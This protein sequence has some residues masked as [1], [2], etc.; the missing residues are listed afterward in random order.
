MSPPTCSADKCA[1]RVRINA[2]K[3][4]Y[5]LRLS[6]FFRSGYRVTNTAAT[7]PTTI[8]TIATTSMASRRHVPY[9]LETSVDRANPRLNAMYGF[10]V[11]RKWQIKGY[12]ERSRAFSG[13]NSRDSRQSGGKSEFER[14]DN[15]R[16]VGY[17]MVVS[18]ISSFAQVHAGN[19]TVVKQQQGH[20]NAC[21]AGEVCGVE[22]IGKR[23]A[24]V[25]VS[26]HRDHLPGASSSSYRVVR[27]KAR[28]QVAQVA[29]SETPV[30]G[31]CYREAAR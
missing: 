18:V 22:C 11:Q 10:R 12:G 13:E 20:C 24:I 23:V 5:F 28:S 1:I 30:N 9:L 19:D 7:G 26:L 17:G 25:V 2:T 8:A 21:P 31:C 29:R 27:V 15:V 6:S 3:M 14:A 4:S 16:L